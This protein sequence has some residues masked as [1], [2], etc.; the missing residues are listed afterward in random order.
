MDCT[1]KPKINNVPGSTKSPR[2]YTSNGRNVSPSPSQ[3]V[4]NLTPKGSTTPNAKFLEIYE[5]EKKKKF[6]RDE[7][8]KQ[9]KEEI[10][11]K[12]LKECTFQPKL[13]SKS[14]L[15]ERKRQAVESEYYTQRTPVGYEDN[16]NRIRMANQEKQR[17]KEQIEK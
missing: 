10:L 15:T 14:P 12:E 13:L 5:T 4:A 16:I 7:K 11:K 8:F 6:E 2:P 1:F 3:L 17:K 9:Q